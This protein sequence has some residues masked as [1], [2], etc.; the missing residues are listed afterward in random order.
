MGTLTERELEVLRLI[1]SEHLSNSQ[2]AQRLTVSEATVESH[3]HHVLQ[4]LQLKQRHE[5]ARAYLLTA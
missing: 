2:V 5:A 1:A 4:K 3:V